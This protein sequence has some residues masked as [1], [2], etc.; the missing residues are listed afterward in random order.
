VK[1]RQRWPWI[2]ALR[3]YDQFFKGTQNPVRVVA[4]NASGKV[5]ARQRL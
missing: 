5:M 3:F 2:K 1:L 4:L